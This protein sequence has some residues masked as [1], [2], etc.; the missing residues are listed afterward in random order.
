MT[1][2]TM[3]TIAAG[4]TVVLKPSEYTPLSVLALAHVM[5]Q[6]LPEGV[7]Q[8]LAGDGRARPTVRP[9]SPAEMRTRGSSGSRLSP[10]SS[11]AGRGPSEAVPR[12]RLG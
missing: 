6:A 2:A 9:L 10:N 1:A 4:N 12:T 3:K 7:L 11:A 5:N 8:V